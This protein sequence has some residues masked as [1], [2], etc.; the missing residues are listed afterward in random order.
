MTY[1]V[2]LKICTS[3]LLKLGTKLK[4]GWKLQRL[5]KPHLKSHSH[6]GEVI[7]KLNYTN[8]TSFLSGRN[9]S[10]LI[11]VASSVEGGCCHLAQSG[12]RIKHKSK[13]SRQRTESLLSSSEQLEFCVPYTCTKSNME[14]NQQLTN[15]T[16]CLQFCFCF[17]CSLHRLGS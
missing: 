14:D 5:N 2:K 15:L 13:C 12:R 17:H 11:Q 1:T 16:Q 8:L 3:I 9:V 10:W 6:P 7:W 4:T